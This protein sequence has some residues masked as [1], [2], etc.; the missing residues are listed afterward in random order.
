MRSFFVVWV[1][2]FK[3]YSTWGYLSTAPFHY[4]LTVTL[5]RGSRV[6]IPECRGRIAGTEEVFAALP[7][8]THPTKFGIVE[9][10]EIQGFIFAHFASFLF[11]SVSVARSP[12]DDLFFCRKTKRAVTNHRKTPEVH[13]RSMYVYSVR[14]HIQWKIARLHLFWHPRYIAI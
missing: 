13:N 8:N 5:Q 4:I 1:W 10:F 2:F 12:W 7:Q 14:H 6:H 3:G 11:E 9:H